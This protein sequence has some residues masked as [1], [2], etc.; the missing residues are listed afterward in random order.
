MKKYYIDYP[1]N[2]SNEYA[3]YS[4]ETPEEKSTIDHMIDRANDDPNRDIHQIT[5]K[6]AERLT[7][8]NRAAYRSGEANN[9]NPAGATQIIQIRETW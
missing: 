6:E 9:N 5:R 1:R 7:A 2:F 4:V 3:I 8:A